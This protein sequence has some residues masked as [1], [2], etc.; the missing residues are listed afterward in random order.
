MMSV[1]GV[2]VL[3]TTGE[4]GPEVGAGVCPRAGCVP[5]E[6]VHDPDEGC[7][8]YPGPAAALSPGN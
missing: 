4:L 6:R 5:G 8:E 1:P 7:G 3:V 2:V